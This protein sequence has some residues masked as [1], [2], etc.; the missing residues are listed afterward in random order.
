MKFIWLTPILLFMIAR[1]R[2]ANDEKHRCGLLRDSANTFQLMLTTE[3]TKKTND[4][5]NKNKNNNKN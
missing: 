1:R 4:I 2:A 5:L 3:R